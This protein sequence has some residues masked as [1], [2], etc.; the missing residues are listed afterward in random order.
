MS[1]KQHSGEI[2]WTQADGIFRLARMSRLYCTAISLSKQKI[3]EAREDDDALS[4]SV[5][6][7]ERPHISFRES[8]SRGSNEACMYGACSSYLH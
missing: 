2:A 3:S 5:L 1:V 8:E 7:D 6:Q 4:R